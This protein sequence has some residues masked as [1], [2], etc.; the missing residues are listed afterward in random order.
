MGYFCFP[1]SLKEN[2]WVFFWKKS[3]TIV[4]CSDNKSRKG[5][6]V[7]DVIP[8]LYFFSFY[9]SFK[10]EKRTWLSVTELSYLWVCLADDLSQTRNIVNE[11]R[12]DMTELALSLFLDFS[13]QLNSYLLSYLL[14]PVVRY[15]EETHPKANTQNLVIQVYCP[16]QPICQIIWGLLFSAK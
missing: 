11:F 4:S 1:I 16:R 14:I 2:Q 12:L 15:K 8:C 3:H 7:A 13:H 9:D 5:G 6:F 10:L